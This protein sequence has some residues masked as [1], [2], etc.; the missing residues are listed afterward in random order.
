MPNN[1]S[2]T[3]PLANTINIT[4][5]LLTVYSNL[6]SY[7]NKFGMTFP[8]I[9]S[10][11]FLNRT[12]KPPSRSLSIASLAPIFISEIYK[13]HGAPK[14]IVSDKDRIFVSQFWRS[15]FKHLRT[16]LA[17]SS[18]YHHKT[19]GQ[20]KVLNRCLETYLRYFVSDEPQF[21]FASSHLRNFAITQLITLQ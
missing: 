14:I 15:L 5:M 17:F 20:T 1:L 7:L 19:D 18:S 11:T 21:G 13:L 8:W 16:T 4:L 2:L 12:I 6:Y 9:S 10:P 3:A